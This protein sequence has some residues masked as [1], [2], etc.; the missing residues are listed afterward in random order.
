[1]AKPKFDFTDKENLLRIEGWAR[2]GLDDKQIAANLR[3]NETYFS[4]LKSK[5]P[6]LSEALKKGR[7]P[8]DI[9]V[10]STLYR[11]A[12]GA[13]I[14]VQQAIKVKEVYYDDEGHKCEKERVEVVELEQEL[15]SDTTAQI[16]WLKNRKP[17]IWNRQPERVDLTTNGK[18]LPAARV[19]SKEEFKEIFNQMNNEY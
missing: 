5:I 13:K 17:D 18:D 14:K 16:F 12:V 9:I 2:D 10:E 1:M 15:P 19:I 4:E 11:R 7:A 8:L 6:E 3:Y